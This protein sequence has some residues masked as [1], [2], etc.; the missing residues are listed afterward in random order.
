M[1]IFQINF[2]RVNNDFYQNLTQD[3]FLNAQR[4]TV[5]FSSFSNTN[6]INSNLQCT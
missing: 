6:V 1:F 3:R 4:L 2:I 5:Q